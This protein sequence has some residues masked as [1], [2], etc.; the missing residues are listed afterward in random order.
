M[1][2]T[3]YSLIQVA[4]IAGITILLLFSWYYTGKLIKPIIESR[5]KQTAFVASASHEL[6]TPIA[7]ICSAV[8][9]S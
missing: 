6:R 2:H 1:N 8:S 7:V 9:A 5:K 4:V 3:A